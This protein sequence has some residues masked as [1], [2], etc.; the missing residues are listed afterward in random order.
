MLCSGTVFARVP[1]DPVSLEANHLL[2]CQTKSG[3]AAG[4]INDADPVNGPS[5]IVPRENGTAVLGLIESFKATGNAAFKDGALLAA[6]YL[7]RR[8]EPDGAWC[9]YYDENAH[10][11]V[12][13]NKSVSQ[14]GS[15]LMAF[16]GI[17]KMGWEDASHQY[18][19]NAK[20]AAAY[21]I[22]SI[23]NKPGTK[24]GLAGAGKEY[25]SYSL[26]D[27]RGSYRWNGWSWVS[28]NCYAYIALMCMGDWAAERGDSVLAENCRRH[29]D[30]VLNGINTSLK[31]PRNAVWYRVVGENG[32]TV[33][34]SEKTDALCYY[35]QKL[36]LPVP[37]RG[38]E[39]VAR[40]IADNLQITTGPVSQGYG[41]FRWGNAFG[42]QSE[43]RS[44]GFALEASLAL[45]DIPGAVSEKTRWL[46]RSWWEADDDTG[47]HGQ[48]WDTTDGG[49]VDWYEPSGNP[50]VAPG[51]QKFI[52][53]S[54]N[55]IFV[56]RGGFNHL[57]RDSAGNDIAGDL[58]ASTPVADGES[59]AFRVYPNPYQPGSGTSFDGQ[60]I[61]FE[62]LSR[63]TDIR[64]FSLTGEEVVRL[65]ESSGSG[66]CLWDAR[67]ASGETVASGVY[68]YL[69][70]APGGQKKEG[71]LAI[72]R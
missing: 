50:A 10:T 34:E 7:Q 3:S 51:W 37:Q 42:P 58:P 64:I 68:V 25:G 20:K 49:I 69:V 63:D 46:A 52:D 67:N 44:Q 30:G 29:A 45:L 59:A 9:E 39:D 21:I 13:R 18:Y 22:A 33:L 47:G 43:R 35:P 36:D 15:V 61:L 70:T 11:V 57:L 26:T 71:K 38:R 40:W 66:K 8:Q 48:L 12:N 41:A 60:G 56:Y 27:D 32:E 55:C 72:I 5:W 62:N 53:T 54:S 31:N 19:E 1:S 2:N 65:R 17:K 28:D 23:D 6:G 24:N 16:F 4:A 14:A